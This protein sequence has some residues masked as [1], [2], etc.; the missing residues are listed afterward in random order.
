MRRTRRKEI[1]AAHLS[2]AI[3]DS[4]TDVDM[5]RRLPTRSGEEMLRA[6]GA[7]MP[8]RRCEA[9]V[10]GSGAAGLRAAVESSAAAS[11]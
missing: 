7:E 6:G 1:V 10:L 9:L 8:V 2:Q 11:T 5:P 3:L 4:L